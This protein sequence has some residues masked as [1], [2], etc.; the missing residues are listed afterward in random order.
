MNYL[1]QRLTESSTYASLAAILAGA[2]VVIP[3]GVWKDVTIGGMFI[4]GI[5]GVVIKEGWRTA[6][7]SGDAIAQGVSDAQQA[8]TNAAA[9]ANV[10]VA[11][12]KSVAKT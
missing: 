9:S 12:A 4:A 7:E 1:L 6:L 10:A 2:G 11:A 8:A 3:P 5:A